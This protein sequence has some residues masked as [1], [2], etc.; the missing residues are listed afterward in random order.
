[1]GDHGQR[2]AFLEEAFQAQPVQRQLLG[3]HTGQQLAR[4]AG[5]K[6]RRQVFLDRHLLPIA[7]HRLVHH[8]KTTRRD[9]ADHAV[10]TNHG[11]GREGS[12]FDL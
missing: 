11:I 4:S 7:V 1:V 12:R 3:L 2:T 9:L 5:G 6:R 8:A 10:T